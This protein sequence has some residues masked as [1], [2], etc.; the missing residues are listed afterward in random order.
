M[1]MK[2]EKTLEQRVS[3][4]EAELKA[5]KDKEKA[6]KPYVPKE[7]SRRYDPTEQFQLP[8]SAVKAMVDVVPDFRGVAREQSAGLSRPGMF[9][10]KGGGKPVVRG[11]GWQEPRPLEGPPG[12]KWVDQQIDVADEIDRR[13]LERKL[14]KRRV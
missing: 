9:P 7:P 12:L 13:E 11:S 5:T 4:L 10:E 8:A 14:G 6:A 3:E 1:E 2:E